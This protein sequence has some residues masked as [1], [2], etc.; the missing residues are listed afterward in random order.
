M[1]SQENIQAM[2]TCQVKIVKA[3]TVQVEQR[4]KVSRLSQFRRSNEARLAGYHSS[5]G[6]TRRD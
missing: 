2:A 1:I 5:G 3:I 6:A 4:G